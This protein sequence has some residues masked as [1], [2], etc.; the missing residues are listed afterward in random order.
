MRDA[1]A[2]TFAASCER[3]FGRL[4]L[5]DMMPDAPARSVAPSG[6]L[7]L[8]A[9]REFSTTAGRKQPG[10]RDRTQAG[11][12]AL[13]RASTS[14]RIASLETS[15]RSAIRRSSPGRSDSATSRG[16]W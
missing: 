9:P 2:K 5:T 1:G 12:P 3:F 10:E 7:P 8:Y 13:A 14:D 11:F 15:C 4:A 16:R 6:E